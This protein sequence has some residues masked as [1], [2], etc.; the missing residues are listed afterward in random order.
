MKR[1]KRTGWKGERERRG[2]GRVDQKVSNSV[3]RQK[4]T[5]FR[6]DFS[7]PLFLAIES[8][9]A[10]ILRH[11]SSLFL[12]YLYSLSH[13]LSAIC[14]HVY[15]SIYRVR[16]MSLCACAHSIYVFHSRSW[17]CLPESVTQKER[18]KERD[19][20]ESTHP[21]ECFVPAF[22]LVTFLRQKF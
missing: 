14:E 18:A 2:D 12:S 17:I 3:L 20:E 4:S 8:T 13:S 7:A 5:L 16:S 21:K 1:N 10:L 22:H 11:S 6:L 15:I 9:F 19:Q